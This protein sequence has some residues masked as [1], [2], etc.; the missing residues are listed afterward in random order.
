M[1]QVLQISAATGLP[2][3]VHVQIFKEPCTQICSVSVGN[4]AI[5]SHHR[6]ANQS[7]EANWAFSEVYRVADEHSRRLAADG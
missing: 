2:Q 4:V 3:L 5:V 6:F 7:W 1:H